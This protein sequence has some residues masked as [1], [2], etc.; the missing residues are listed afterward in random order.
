MSCLHRAASSCQDP[1][2]NLSHH[3]SEVTAEANLIALVVSDKSP[4]GFLEQVNR[5]LTQPVTCEMETNWR[6]LKDRVNFS[7]WQWKQAEWLWTIYSRKMQ[8]LRPAQQQIV[9]SLN[10]NNQAASNSLPIHQPGH[11]HL[12][13]LLDPAEALVDNIKLMQETHL[14]AIRLMAFGIC[15]PWQWGHILISNH[16][17]H[18]DAVGFVRYLATRCSPP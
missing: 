3:F 18:C 4:Q 17:Y 7:R 11:H 9:T 14:H 6:A 13:A 15:T 10:I 16:P 1:T 12:P 2:S 8:E 5:H